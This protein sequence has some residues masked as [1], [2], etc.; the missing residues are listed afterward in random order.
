MLASANTWSLTNS[1]ITINSDYITAKTTNGTLNVANNL[2]SNGTLNLGNIVNTNN[3][4]GLKI[5]DTVIDTIND[6][7]LDIGT[8]S[9]T[10][11]NLGSTENAVRT[12]HNATSVTEIVNFRTMISNCVTESGNNIFTGT[13]TFNTVYGNDFQAYT[14][15]T[16][17]FG[18]NATDI[19]LGGALVPVR[20]SYNAVGGDD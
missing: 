4:G 1:F 7:F 13:N 6:T 10:V 12:E 15:N 20:S 16:V 5:I 18:T 3:I 11:I 19:N 17:N 9:T 14:A 8:G 2:L